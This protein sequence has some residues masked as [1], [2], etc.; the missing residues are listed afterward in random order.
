MAIEQVGGRGRLVVDPPCRLKWPNDLMVDGRKLGGIL[1]ETVGRGESVAA[2]V[3]F[4]VNYANGLT[5]TVSGSTSVLDLARQAPSLGDLAGRLIEATIGAVT[6]GRSMAEVIE[7]YSSWS[8][9]QKGQKM[10]CRTPLE[11]CSGTFVGFNELGFLRLRT[12]EGERILSA[13]DLTETS[14]A[15]QRV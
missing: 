7:E 3:G 4:G 5:E 6:E 15:D 12:H 10:S 2:I 13:G 11:T 9:H 8:L 14:E 1:T